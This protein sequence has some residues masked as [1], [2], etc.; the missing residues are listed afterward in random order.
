MWE[1]T[2]TLSSDYRSAG[3][4]SREVGGRGCGGRGGGRGLPVSRCL[5][6]EKNYKK[7]RSEIELIAYVLKQDQKRDTLLTERF[8]E[9]TGEDNL[10]VFSYSGR[11]KSPEWRRQR[12]GGDFDSF[13]S[14][15][16]NLL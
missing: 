12:R 15:G 13:R 14:S 2:H 10:T 7:K 11:V 4:S 6:G 16:V 3:T 8:P 5:E 1:G 9:I